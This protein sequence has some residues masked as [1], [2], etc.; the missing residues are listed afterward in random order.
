MKIA[1]QMKAN[2][3]GADPVWAAA[4]ADLA[5]AVIERAANMSAAELRQFVAG[6]TAGARFAAAGDKELQATVAVVASTLL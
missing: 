2:L 3:A 5:H 6:T 4:S 1:D